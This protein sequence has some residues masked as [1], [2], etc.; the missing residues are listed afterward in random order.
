VALGAVAALAGASVT[1]ILGGVLAVSAGLLVV[2]VTTGYA[3]SLA[4]TSGDDDGPV[5]A[6]AARAGSWPWIAAG[7]AVTGVAVGQLGLW[8]F[9]RTEGGVLA[10]PD[11]LGQTFGLLVPLEGLV[12]GVVAWWRTR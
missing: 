6:G 4:V 1:V 11:Y 3:V 8:L 9:A 10:L 5:R 7:L 12:A 2:A